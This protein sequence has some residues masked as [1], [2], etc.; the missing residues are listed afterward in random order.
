MLPKLKNKNNLFLTTTSFFNGYYSVI[1]YFFYETNNYPSADAY[2]HTSVIHH[3]CVSFNLIPIVKVS[4]IEIKI[5]DENQKKDS[6]LKR[7]YSELLEN[8]KSKKT[9]LKKL[10]NPF[11]KAGKKVVEIFK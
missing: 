6:Y 7:K 10:L 5:N 2:F 11:I 3:R 9:V 8:L 4:N 1:H